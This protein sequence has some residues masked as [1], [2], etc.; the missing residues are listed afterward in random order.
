MTE[1]VRARRATAPNRSGAMT[2][3]ARQPTV[4]PY[5]KLGKLNELKSVCNCSVK[6]YT[7][8]WFRCVGRVTKKTDGILVTISTFKNP[9]QSA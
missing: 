6:F 7:S 5:N 8:K 1:R 4:S 2:E 9:D 3:M